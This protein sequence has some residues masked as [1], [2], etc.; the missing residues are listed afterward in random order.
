MKNHRST[1]TP[2]LKKAY[3]F[4]SKILP[5]ATFQQALG[6]WDVWAEMWKLAPHNTRTTDAIPALV[7]CDSNS[8]PVINRLLQVIDVQPVTT[9]SPERS[10]SNLRRLKTSLHGTMKEDRLSGMALMAI[11]RNKPKSK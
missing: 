6:E 1:S 10:V 2:I 3:S 4:W 7:K 9:A 5:H 8:F 11:N